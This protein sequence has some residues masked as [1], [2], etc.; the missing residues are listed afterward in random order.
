VWVYDLRTNVP[1]VTKGHSLDA[2]YFTDFV[3]SYGARP[4]PAPGER[5]E[6]GRFHR[7]TRQEIADRGENLDIFW[8]KDES[9]N[10]GDESADLEGLLGDMT[11][12]LETALSALNELA[13]TLGRTGNGVIGS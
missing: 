13:A 7:F 10:S 1:K 12:Q 6:S 9:G 5:Q 4:T 8:L 2:E 11:M 3:A